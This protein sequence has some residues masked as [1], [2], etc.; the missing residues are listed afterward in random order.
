MEYDRRKDFTKKAYEAIQKS[1][2]VRTEINTGTRTM[3]TEKHPSRA[4]EKEG[5]RKIIDER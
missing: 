2:R 1:R 3:K 5:L 4:M